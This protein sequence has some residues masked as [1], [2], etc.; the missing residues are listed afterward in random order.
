MPVLMNAEPSCR[1]TPLPTALTGKAATDGSVPYQILG[2]WVVLRMSIYGRSKKRM[3]PQ[4]VWGR[5]QW[6]QD[7]VFMLFDPSPIEEKKCFCNM[8][9]LKCTKT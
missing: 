9:Q 6:S 7:D 4:H 1:D 8:W 3:Q 2:Q 5:K